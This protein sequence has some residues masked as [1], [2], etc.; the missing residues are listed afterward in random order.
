[1]AR[2][3]IKALL[4]A[5]GVS[6]TPATELQRNWTYDDATGWTGAVTSVTYDLTNTTLLAASPNP[7]SDARKAVWFLKLPSGSNFEQELAKITTPSA[8]SV[9]VDTGDFV[10]PAGTYR[11]V[12]VY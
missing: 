4:F 8:T 6:V 10:L 12:G 2:G 5:D 3:E 7:P 1:M 11:L 9:V